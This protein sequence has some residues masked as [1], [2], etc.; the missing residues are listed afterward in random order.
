MRICFDCYE[1]Q[2]VELP[3]ARFVLISRHLAKIANRNN[4]PRYPWSLARLSFLNDPQLRARDLWTLELVSGIR[5]WRKDGK[6]LF[7]L[8]LEGKLMVVEVKGGQRSSPECHCPCFRPARVNL[9]RC[10]A[11][12]VP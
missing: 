1:L 7:C 6:E 9:N 10:D 12:S 8:T 2:A 11:L 4:C 3:L 5:M